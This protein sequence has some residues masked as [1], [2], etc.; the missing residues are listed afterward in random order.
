MS[1]L[2]Q[3]ISLL[4][5]AVLILCG[6]LYMFNGKKAAE[7]LK[8]LLVVLL[9]LP[10]GISFLYQYL[11]GWLGGFSNVLLLLF[12]CLVAYFVWQHRLHPRGQERRAPRPERMPVAPHTKDE[13]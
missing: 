2:L 3:L 7:I 6:F 8:K 1:V 9:L 11:Q 4:A 10:L 12:I 5:A 13:E